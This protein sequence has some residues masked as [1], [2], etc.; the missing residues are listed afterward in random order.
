MSVVTETAHRSSQD[1]GRTG[2]QRDTGQLVQ[3]A[4]VA[5]L[6]GV[7]LAVGAAAGVVTAL[8]AVAA[9]QALL[10]A[11]WVLAVRLPGRNGALILGAA[12]AAAADAATMR[13]YEHGYESVLGVIGVAIPLMFCHQLIRGVVR[14]RVVES[15]SGIAVLVIA[16]CAAVGLLLLRRQDGGDLLMAGIAISAGVAL[17]VQQIVD[18]LAPVARFDPVIRRG[19]PGAVLGI[20]AGCA[21]G[22]V[23]MHDV[24]GLSNQHGALV[25]AGVAAIAC[26]L[27][28]GTSFATA[29]AGP[30]A[31]DRAA[32]R[33]PIVGPV[34]TVLLTICLTVPAGYV[35][36][37]ALTTS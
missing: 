21:A 23:R 10:V 37:N 19:L 17:F 28:V 9:I 36:V 1:V 25:A 15:L 33:L 26:L 11:S 27:S 24:A 22:A 14:T 16:V 32:G 8:V 35:L 2:E 5:A 31:A 30:A 29:E 13:W 7:V 3:G 34:S 18:V 6:A 20:A 12:A 4:T